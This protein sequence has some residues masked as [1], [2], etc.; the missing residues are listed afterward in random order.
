MTDAL[1]N[2]P[3]GPQAD[4][5]QEQEAVQNP[6][7]NLIPE[8]DNHLAPNTRRSNSVN[9]ALD[10]VLGA[11]DEAP[12]Q[13]PAPKA[14]PEVKAEIK[15]EPP[16]SDDEAKPADE[17]EPV[18]PRVTAYKEPPSG[19]DLAAK[20]EWEAVP[21][22]VRGAMH[23]RAQEMEAGIAKYKTEAQEFEPVRP[24][25]EMAKQ[26]GTTLDQ[27]LARYVGMEQQLRKDPIAGLEAVVANLGLKG[28]NG[29]PAT[30]R[31][32]AAHILGQ[33]P[34]QL[35]SRQE[36]TISQ[37]SRQL[38]EV[39]QKLGGFQQHVEGQ[40]MQAKTQQAESEWGAFQREYPRAAELEAP[41]ADFLTKYPA[42]ANMQIKERLADAYAWAVAK[43]PE[44]VHTAAL[45]LVQT[46][47]PALPNPAGQKSISGAPGGNETRTPTRNLNRSAAVE[48]AMR[49]VGL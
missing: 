16:K 2:A 23:R 49:A 32:V 24:Y 7:T 44:G 9:K 19:F 37:L 40:Q 39:T 3:E 20:G 4:T 14:K 28:P 1:S 35:A 38:Q 36:A 6:Q 8:D 33:K 18:K 43:S 47:T 21:E 11:D 31:D 17:P 12:K 15:A 25:A 46:Q 13:K 26:S 5:L 29:Q 45:P 10:D 30:L 41:I 48:K 22:S 27:A 34:D 42:P